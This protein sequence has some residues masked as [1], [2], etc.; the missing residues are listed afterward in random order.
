MKLH[1]GCGKKHILGFVHV[2]L[3]DYPHVD[4]RVPV[5]KLIFASDNSVEV[6]Y[7]SHVLEHF[8]QP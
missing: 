2:D 6:I 7:V 4:Y 5:D 1:L 8:G 3:E